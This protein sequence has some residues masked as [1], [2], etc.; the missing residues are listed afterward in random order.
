MDP[1]S[2]IGLV[3]EVASI[4]Q[5]LY[6]YG[7]AVK[8]A[9][10][11]IISL[12][13][14]LTALKSTL[15]LCAEYRNHAS[16]GVDGSDFQKMLLR[17]RDILGDLAKAARPK[18]SGPG[19]VLQSLSWPFT[20]ATVKEKLV[21]L[22]RLKTYFLMAFA[23]E[24]KTASEKLHENMQDLLTL[25]TEKQMEERQAEST[26]ERRRLLD[27][28]APTSPDSMHH[29]A[30]RPWRGTATGMWFCKGKLTKFL[31]HE[32]RI[33]LLTGRSGSGKTTIMSRAIEEAKLYSEQ[34]PN[35]SV[36]Y[37]YCAYN[38]LSTRQARNILGSWVAQL[39]ADNQSIL[40]SF[41]LKLERN[42]DI[43]TEHLEE[44][45][46]AASREHRIVLLLD[47]INE[48][49]HGPDLVTS[50]SRLTKESSKIQFILS[51]T[52][53]YPPIR[54]HLHIPTFNVSMSPKD[55]EQDI[56]L[57][58]RDQI[59]QHRVLSRVPAEEIVRVLRPKSEGM[60]RWVDCQ[61]SFLTAQLT[62]N[63]VRAALQTLPGSL[64]S[65]Y[66]ATLRRVAPPH[67]A[68]VKQALMWLSFCLRPL[69]LNELC[70]AVLFEEGQRSIDEGD[71][72]DEPGDIVRKCITYLLMDPFRRTSGGVKQHQ[73]RL[74]DYV[75]K[76]WAVHAGSVT[77]TP[78]ETNLIL[79]FFETQRQREG[80]N[81]A[82][83]I[84]HLVPGAQRHDNPTAKSEPLYYAASYGLTDI[85]RILAESGRLTTN[86][87]PRA[88][89]GEWYVDKKGGR[90]DSTAL[91]VACWRGHAEIVELLLAA[92]ASPNSR[93][94]SGM[95]CVGAARKGGRKRIV[96]MLVEAGGK[97]RGEASKGLA[98]R[99]VEER[100]PDTTGE[101]M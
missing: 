92:G 19:R 35:V 93:D 79:F 3:T 45:L 21:A 65:T 7:Q 98:V 60:F 28:I 88:G 80:G 94:A 36:A 57:Y 49:T 78:A 32:D 90:H 10:K 51:A 86:P 46:L 68:L 15:A 64:D 63:A 40:D 41:P 23:L 30:C 66:E 87:H 6:D 25:V 84:Q 4:I 77:L 99:R 96:G 13:G 31:D 75:S 69:R 81:F 83:W 61:L 20:A 33:L 12:C 53:H 70:E 97:E 44:C 71:R 24:N 5:T 100:V 34:H 76:L 17:T 39:A 58:I 1:V 18:S 85:V 29:N 73:Y 14:E 52:P 27:L 22:E 91:Q 62:P 37:F 26:S 54:Q 95:S 55:I 9:Q 42:T 50:I 56:E 43:T 47:A 72:M 101:G 48:S 11:D 2:A 16:P 38:D 8:N 74:L 89:S 59:A 67:A 82:F